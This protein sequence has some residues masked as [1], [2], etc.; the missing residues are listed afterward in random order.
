[1]PTLAGSGLS[2]PD[3][4]DDDLYRYLPFYRPTSGHRI[5]VRSRA[6]GMSPKKKKCHLKTIRTPE[7]MEQVLAPNSDRYVKMIQKFFLPTLQELLTK[8]GYNK[9]GLQPTPG[10]PW[11]F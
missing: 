4:H 11:V 6:T 7:N 2:G 8:C 3:I 10:F 1:M 9:M 5:L